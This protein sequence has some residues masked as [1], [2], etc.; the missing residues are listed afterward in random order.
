MPKE[1]YAKPVIKSEELE[2]GALGGYGSPEGNQ[3]DKA[4]LPNFQ[5][6]SFGF[7]CAS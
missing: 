1:P 4:W 6:P 7:C 3:Q 2:A 5:N